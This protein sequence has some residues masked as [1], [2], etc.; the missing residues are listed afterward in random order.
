M[1]REFPVIERS[2]IRWVTC[3]ILMVAAFFITGL[4]FERFKIKSLILGAVR[5][6]F[7]SILFCLLLDKDFLKKTFRPFKSKD[8]LYILAGLFITVILIMIA[9]VAVKHFNFKGQSNPI[10]GYLKDVNIFVLIAST[11][12]QF[13]G[14]ELLFVVPFLFVINKFKKINYN[15]RVFLALVISSLLFGAIHMQTYGSLIQAIALIGFLR[16]GVS[17]SY[18]LS[19]S[20]TVSYITHGIYDWILIF[21]TMNSDK[22]LNFLFP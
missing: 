4:L 15:L 10:T 20:L 1:K 5:L 17:M 13:I 6:S 21:L 9:S 3:Y 11:W 16:I 14:E 12:I 18:V 8:I 7:F 22:I 2:T 19:K